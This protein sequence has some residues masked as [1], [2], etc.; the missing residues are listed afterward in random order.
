MQRRIFCWNKVTGKL[1]VISAGLGQGVAI[2]SKGSISKD[3]R[4]RRLFRQS[5]ITD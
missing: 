4:Y 5:S 1:D 2:A 3:E